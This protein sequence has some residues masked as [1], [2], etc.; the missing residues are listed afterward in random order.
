MLI[1]G[2]KFFGYVDFID[3]K[4]YVATRFHHCC[5]IP[6]IY[7]GSYIVIND[8]HA[9]PTPFNLKSILFAYLRLALGVLIIAAIFPLLLLASDWSWNMDHLGITGGAIG[10]IILSSIASF[11][12]FKLSKANEET[13]AKILNRIETENEKIAVIGPVKVSVI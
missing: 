9:L 7:Q 6:L 8:T 5:L 2:T 1:W 13:Q 11:Y 4:A 10:V 12:S 3:E